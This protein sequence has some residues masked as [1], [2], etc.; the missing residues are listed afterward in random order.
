MTPGA[1]AVGSDTKVAK[2]KG[3]RLPP[4]HLSLLVKIPLSTLF[5]VRYGFR[6]RTLSL[7]YLTTG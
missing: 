6:L 4:L 3:K 5:A 2:V 1:V 7:N